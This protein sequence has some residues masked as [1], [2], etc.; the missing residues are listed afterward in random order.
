[1]FNEKTVF[2]LG[3]G[4]S[5][6]Y[7]YPTGEQ[8]IE[9][10]KVV[11]QAICDNGMIGDQKIDENLLNYLL[12]ICNLSGN[13]RNHVKDFLERLQ[14]FSPLSIDFFLSVNEDLGPIG[15]FLI[16]CVIM[17]FDLSPTQKRTV[18]GDWL[19]FIVTKLCYFDSILDKGK[20]LSDNQ[21]Q[22]ITFNYDMSLEERL[23]AAFESSGKF[24][25]QF[26]EFIEG[27]RIYHVYGKLDAQAMDQD[28]IEF[29]QSHLS[30]KNICIYAAW[31][32]SKK[33]DIVRT[34]NNAFE[35]KRKIVSSI[36]KDA[37]NI[38]ILGFGFAPE[39][40]EILNLAENLKNN[41]NNSRV[42]VHFTN[43]T[44]SKII[45][46]KFAKA[47]GLTQSERY[48]V[49]NDFYN[50][51]LIDDLK[52]RNDRDGYQVEYE[53][54]QKLEIEKS[55]RDVYDALAYDFAL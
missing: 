21:I 45:N 30:E 55:T 42:K 26:D 36:L 38:F 52:L 1:M 31:C 53:L 32:A 50:P 34:D 5:Y 11:A 19:K 14:D 47:I 8:L 37:Q 40:C 54:L 15:K 18:K 51:K 44:D 46:L 27:E 43:F 10:I 7:G 4:A 2:I 35:E 20:N 49:K 12:N 17:D 22:F 6:H 3:A 28:E 13:L 23:K 39:N 48:F 16:A 41:K 29:Q 33:I 25:G 24:R 9:R